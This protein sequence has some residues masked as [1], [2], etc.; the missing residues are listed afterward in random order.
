MIRE[1]QKKIKSDIQIS[2]KDYVNKILEKKIN[3][4]KKIQIL[5]I[6]L[7]NRRTPKVKIKQIDS[8]NQLRTCSQI[9]NSQKKVP[10]LIS[11]NGI[12]DENI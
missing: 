6:I 2:K 7:I 8:K 5:K 11:L 3:L 4:K 10:L 1:K 12:R 9:S